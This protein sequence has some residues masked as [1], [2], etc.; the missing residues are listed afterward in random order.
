MR[1]LSY[2]M[3]V[4]GLVAAAATVSADDRV[5]ASKKGSLLIMSKV[6]IRWD[7]SGRL[8]QDTF[9][10]LTNDFPDDVIVQLYFVNGDGP[11]DAVEVGNPP[12]PIERAHPGW[13]NVDC[14]IMLTKDQ[15]TYWSALSGSN[16]MGGVCQ[17]FTVLDP[18]SPMGRPDLDGGPGDRVLRGY[19]L[20]WAVDGAGEE[21]RWNHLKADVVL[22]NYKHTA[23]WEYNAWSYQAVT[24]NHGDPS[25]GTPGRLRTDGTEYDWSFDKLLFDF[26]ATGS[27]ALSGGGSTV[28]VD[29]DL[30]LHPVSAD[31]RQDTRG[32]VF[33]KAVFDIWNMNEV[34]F[35]GTNRCISC[36]DQTLL[37]KYAVVANHFM[38]SNLQTD[39]GKARI[40]GVRSNVCEENPGACDEFNK[41]NDG[42][43][44]CRHDIFDFDGL[45]FDCTKND[46]LLGV[47]AKILSFSGASTGTA[48]AGSNLVG[49][50]TENARIK[51]DII[52]PPDE[53]ITGSRLSG[54]IDADLDI[55]ARIE[56]A[57]TKS[58]R[59][60]R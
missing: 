52:E 2:V 3:C 43:F 38:R 34:R 18:G 12:I 60:R 9:I 16:S 15:P 44:Q 48:Y 27:T 25:D 35:S 49:Q 45:P 8:T 59:R 13:N 28:Q 32:A 57:P 11:L 36:W 1:K 41:C 50:G 37:S 54:L 5:S 55:D 42:F 31:L 10:D 30:T 23:A 26:Y 4:C 7:A 21:I 58:S 6:E 47:S 39:K 40:D 24:A 14:Q 46:P 19:V 20:A 51:Y 29:T 33:T 22:V 17:P 56:R 53:L